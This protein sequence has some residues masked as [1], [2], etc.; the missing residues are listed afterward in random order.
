MNYIIIKDNKVLDVSNKEPISV[1]EGVV[2]ARCDN[3]PP[4][5][6]A[7]GEY[8]EAINIQEKSETYIIKEPKEVFKKDEATGEE[9]PDVEY[10]E[11]EKERTFYTCEL[12]VKQSEKSVKRIRLRKLKSWFD[13]EYRYY[14][15]KLTRFKALGI[16]DIVIDSTFNIVYTSLES[17]YIQ[18]EK[19]RAEINE[20]EALLKL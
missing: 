20:L 14:S 17:L 15:E 18:A 7:N 19:I 12:S 5:N 1:S 4:L 2:V 9:Y 13:T 11:V 6:N 10:V 16:S 3:I 8:Y